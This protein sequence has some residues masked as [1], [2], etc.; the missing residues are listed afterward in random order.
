MCIEI[1]NLS[2]KCKTRDA[3]GKDAAAPTG[4]GG[5]AAAGTAREDRPAPDWRL[6]ALRRL[7]DALAERKER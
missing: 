6:D 2:I 5:T 3:A 7:Q 4:K 1:R